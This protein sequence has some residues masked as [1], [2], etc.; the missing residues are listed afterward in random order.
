[1]SDGITDR[2]RQRLEQ[3]LEQ[4]L[5]SVVVVAEAVHRRHNTSAILRSAEAFGLHEVH[6]VANSFRPSKGA[7]RGS[8]K[9]LD[10]HRH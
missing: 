8:E 3:T 2:R 10:I 7:A 5:G 1:M 6:L 4:R 9:W